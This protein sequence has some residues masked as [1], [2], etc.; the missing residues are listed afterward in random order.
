[1]SEHT[2]NSTPQYDRLLNLSAMTTW[3]ASRQQ[4]HAADAASYASALAAMQAGLRSQGIDGDRRWDAARR[5]RRV[6]KHLKRMVKAARKQE[7]AAEDLRNAYATHVAHV[8]ALP[9]QREE[10][11][12]AKQLRKGP[13]HVVEEIAAKSLNKSAAALADAPSGEAAPSETGPADEPKKSPARGVS[14]LWQRG[15]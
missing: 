12:A 6:E 11:R 9:G 8:A 15:A 2:T 14:D 3:T 13:R 4:E 10:K 5:S 7:R 1:M